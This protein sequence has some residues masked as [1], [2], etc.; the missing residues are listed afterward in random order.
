LSAPK[1]RTVLQNKAAVNE[2]SQDVA[3]HLR[4]E[5]ETVGDL[6]DR[7]TS[8]G[9]LMDS[10]QHLELSDRVDVLIDEFFNRR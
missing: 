5:I 7:P 1:V 10:E 2:I 3:C 4:L 6:L 9:I 8:I